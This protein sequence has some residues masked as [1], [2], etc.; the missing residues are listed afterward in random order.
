[1]TPVPTPTVVPPAQPLSLP[2]SAPEPTPTNA[3]SPTDT[4]APNRSPAAQPSA[5]PSPEEAADGTDATQNSDGVE[6]SVDWQAF[7]PT[8][9]ADHLAT[10]DRAARN[11]N[12]GVPWQLLAA[13]ARVES[14]FGRNMSTSSAGAIGYGQ[15]LPSSW[16]AYGS[17]GNPYD[18]RTVLPAIAQYLC[19]AGLDRDPRTALFAYNHA[20]W[21]VDLVL[22]LA[23]R[24]DR[25]APGAPTPD[26]LDVSPA[27]QD[28]TP[29][30]YADGRNLGVQ[31]Q[32]RVVNDNGTVNWLGV[33]WR[34][35]TAGQPISAAA[36]ETTTLSMLRLATGAHGDAPAVASS[37]VAGSDNLASVGDAAWDAGLLALPDSGP[38]WTVQELQQH[39][40]LGQPVVVF[41]GSRGLPGHPPGEDLGEQP[42]VLIGSTQDGFVY[43]DPTFSSS[44]GYG[45][46]MSNTDLLTAWD[47]AKRP[48]QALAFV[49]RPTPPAH[50]SHI[51]EAQPPDAI[52]RVEP[53]GTP[54]PVA[55]QPTDEPTLAPPT[56][57]DVVVP[58]DAT[59]APAA[60]A[61]ADKTTPAEPA[62]WSWTVLVG[63]A[64]IGIGTALVRLRRARRWF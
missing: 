6:A 11:S 41:V 31:S 21:Y 42:L 4:P 51:A 12:C 47:A 23:V 53:T 10:M 19:Q 20:D 5:S 59:V 62:D 39:L 45:L 34:G 43:S 2:T 32:A 27:Q 33:P 35:R 54:V 17:D 49:P 48:R 61:V 28:A 1:M 50:L 44:L 14:D 46:Q 15:F 8:D 3:P 9:V 25:M 57:T 64:A 38:Q 40:G 22:D 55:V 56:P 24:Y 37:D 36:L 16:Q 26:V 60:A 52:A 58:S 30:H 18:Y 63:V 7:V 13:I 29:M